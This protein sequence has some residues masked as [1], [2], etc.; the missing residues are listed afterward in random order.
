MSPLSDTQLRR[1]RKVPDSRTHLMFVSVAQKV[2]ANAALVYSHLYCSL[3]EM[4]EKKPVVIDGVRWSCESQ[5][6]MLEE[7]LYLSKTQLVTCLKNLQEA[8]LIIKKEGSGILGQPNLY[9]F[10]EEQVK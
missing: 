3:N 2:G 1:S 10:P 6:D 9:T 4:N 8:G 5:F 7:L